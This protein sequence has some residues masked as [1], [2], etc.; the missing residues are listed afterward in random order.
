MSEETRLKPEGTS[1]VPAASAPL[2]PDELYAK[3]SDIVK[4]SGAE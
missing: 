4:K 3:L 2:D 1:S